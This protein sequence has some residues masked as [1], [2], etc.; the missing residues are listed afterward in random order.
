MRLDEPAPS[1]ADAARSVAAGSPP[2]SASGTGRRDGGESV[3]LAHDGE[4]ARV[5][6]LCE[7]VAVERAS[8]AVWV[9]MAS[10]P[11]PW[12]AYGTSTKTFVVC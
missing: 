12:S 8:L 5:H 11:R 4:R 3:S 7:G 2:V 1:R 6:D 9:L 10:P